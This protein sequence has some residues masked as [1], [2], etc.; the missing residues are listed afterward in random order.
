MVQHHTRDI[1]DAVVFQRPFAMFL[2]LISEK[3][4]E[5]FAQLLAIQLPVLPAGVRIESGATS[6]DKTLRIEGMSAAEAAAL[7]GVDTG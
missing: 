3:L 6:R 4:M 5:D 1:A 7:L 2:K